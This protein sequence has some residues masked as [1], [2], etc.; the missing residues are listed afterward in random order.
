MH[1]TSGQFLCLAS[2]GVLLPMAALAQRSGPT[3]ANTAAQPQSEPSPTAAAARGADVYR[4]SCAFCHGGD[5]RGG[6]APDLAA[7]LIVI[8]DGGKGADIASF[9]KVGSPERGMPAFAA[10]PSDQVNDLAAFLHS[11]VTDAR[12][13]QPMDNNAIVV[14]DAKAG[15]AYFKGAGK[16]SGCH[17]A[18]GDLQGIGKKYDAA[19]VQD[20]MMNPRA[21]RA[22]AAPPRGVTVHLPSSSTVEGTL[23]SINDF[24]VTL[25][26]ANGTLRTFS[27]DND[28][29]KVEIHDP[30]QAHLEMLLKMTDPTMHNLTAYLVTLK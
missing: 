9:L 2:L 22:S 1:R 17:S 10:L 12:Q 7:S 27:R 21:A 26:D 8:N 16:C 24:F 28:V 25:R 4:S 14:G 19:T 20:R 29:P 23:V 3:P 11:V 5:A 15:E 18:T 6:L 30:A 13:N